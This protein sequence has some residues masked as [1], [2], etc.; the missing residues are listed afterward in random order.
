MEPSQIT[1]VRAS[2]T[3]LSARAP[4][5]A[6]QFY[7]RLFERDPSLRPL[8]RGDMARQGL[9]LMTTLQ[10]A[11]GALDAPSQIV[12]ALQHLARTHLVYGVRD[13]HYATV[14][15]ALLDA[16]AEAEGEWFTA[17]LREAWAAAYGFISGVMRE[18]AGAVMSSAA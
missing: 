8:F 7:A 4:A 10:L 16:L 13:E 15:E 3:R 17:E 6:A 1:L 14:G 18:A 12:P 11:V 2:F 5:L 9:K